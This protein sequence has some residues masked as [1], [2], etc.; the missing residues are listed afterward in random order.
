MRVSVESPA[1]FA[2]AVMASLT[3]RRGNILGVQEQSGQARA[4]AEV[5]LSEMFGYATSLRSMT[6]GKA[7]FTMEFARYLPVPESIAGELTEAARKRKLAAS[8]A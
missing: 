6:E 5:P 2:G 1:A 4:D 7:E 8:K 3:Q